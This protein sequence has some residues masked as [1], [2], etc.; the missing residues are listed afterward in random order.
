GEIWAE[1]SEVVPGGAQMV[2]NDIKDYSQAAAVAGVDQ[3]LEPLRTSIGVV[4]RVKIDTIV[5]PTAASGKFCHRH[6]LDMTDAEV[7]QIIEFI[8]GR[9]EG[10]FRCEGSDMKLVDRGGRKRRRLPSSIRPRKGSVIDEGAK[11]RQYRSAA[12]ENAGRGPV[13]RH[14]GG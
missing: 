6:Q 12:R 5:S 8:D 10:S 14:R 4:R 1:V 3:A 7:N 13:V 9:D 11:V 2:V